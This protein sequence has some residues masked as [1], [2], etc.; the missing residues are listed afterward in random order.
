[1]SYGRVFS[2]CSML[3]AAVSCG[4]E[5]S[6]VEAPIASMS[7]SKGGPTDAADAGTAQAPLRGSEKAAAPLDAVAWRTDE[8]AARVA[9][10]DQSRPVIIE[11]RA[12]WCRACSEL[13][14]AT[15]PDADVRR[16]SK[17][18]VAIRIDLTDDETPEA[19]DL[20]RRFAVA[21]LPT[22]LFLDAKGSERA[23][24]TEFVT[25][26]AMVSTMQ[27]VH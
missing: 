3:F 6:R 16:E 19:L 12:S 27:K 22:I 23:R 15:W 21:G 25:P 10:L 4:G 20:K 1:M 26:S 11:F 14:K 2:L 24:I 9:A 7:G 8:S 13:E 18:F 5:S 17:R